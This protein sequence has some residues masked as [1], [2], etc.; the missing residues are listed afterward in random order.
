MKKIFLVSAITL[1]LGSFG[2]V[3]AA[4][5]LNNENT[6]GSI[7]ITYSIGQSYTITIPETFS[8]TA[9]N[10]DIPKTVSAS[11]VLINNDTKLQVVISGAHCTETGWFLEDVTDTDNDVEYTVKKDDVA[12]K[13]GDT[14]LEV[15]AGT[16]QAEQEIVFNLKEG[17]KKAGTYKDTLTFTSS[18]V[19][20][21]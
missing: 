20:A 1:M 17:I 14:V 9:Q 3:F 2:T 6:K 10:T 12:L 5:S 11:S 19:A 16:Q 8:F 7:D 13:N 15:T 21:Q 4:G 18:I